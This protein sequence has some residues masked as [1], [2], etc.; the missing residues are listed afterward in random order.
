MFVITS[1]FMPP[2]PTGVAERHVSSVSIAI[3]RRL[4]SSTNARALGLFL[5]AMLAKVAPVARNV[6][7][8]R[9]GASVTSLP[10]LITARWA[11]PFLKKPFCV[12][13][14]VHR[15]FL[16]PSPLGSTATSM[17]TTAKGNF[18]ISFSGIEVSPLEYVP[19]SRSPVRSRERSERVGGGGWLSLGLPEAEKS[20][21]GV[22]LIAGGTKSAVVRSA[23]GP[24]NVKRRT[25]M[26]GLFWT[27]LNATTSRFSILNRGAT[28]ASPLP[29]RTSWRL[30]PCW[31]SHTLT[32]SP[33]AIWKR[34]V[35]L[36]ASISSYVTASA[37]SPLTPSTIGS[38]VNLILP[39]E[40]RTL[41]PGRMSV[42]STTAP[43][44][45]ASW[46]RCTVTRPRTSSVRPRISPVFG[47]RSS[48]PSRYAVN[49]TPA[50]SPSRCPSE[51]VSVVPWTSSTSPF[52]LG[53]SARTW[54]TR[55]PSVGGAVWADAP[56]A[57]RRS[58]ARTAE[59]CAGR[60]PFTI[61]GASFSHPD[62]KMKRGM[63]D[64]AHAPLCCAR[65]R[66]DL[67]AEPQAGRRQV[68]VV[69]LP[70]REHTVE[71]LAGI[72]CLP[73]REIRTR[74]IERHVRGEFPGEA[75]AALRTEV[76]G[77]TL[78]GASDVSTSSGRSL[79]RIGVDLLRRPR[80]VDR[81][82]PSEGRRER[83]RPPQTELATAVAVVTDVGAHTVGAGCA[84]ALVV[85][86]QAQD[87]GPGGVVARVEVERLEV[88][89]LPGEVVAGLVTRAVDPAGLEEQRPQ[90]VAPDD[91][92]EEGA[93]LCLDPLPVRAAGGG[94]TQN[95]ASTPLVI[96]GRIES[97]GAHAPA[98]IGADRVA[99]LMERRRAVRG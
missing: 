67:E 13:G 70:L 57:A 80:R 78:D 33:S 71:E 29:S 81:H 91:V 22:A 87:R 28:G 51:S 73:C 97:P 68:A 41:S 26:Y 88:V 82:P 19:A 65:W 27:R 96:E 1:S 46:T 7:G 6:L 83:V 23:L 76:A 34:P 94:E 10:S 38:S 3:R 92:E 61:A 64:T 30:I 75:Y 44:A 14:W 89:N 59:T 37:R 20:P 99:V 5:P 15:V 85:D 25:S 95:V 52:T 60:R 9:T 21:F 66:A 32:A 54:L 16:I 58:R 56:A 31:A 12:K 49:S 11:S 48:R 79:A 50:T 36:S 98:R 8:T 93:H 40:T 77:V 72:Q 47:W 90:L 4:Y 35:R 69:R 45:Y 42:P 84:A 55:T 53:K 39:A 86:T 63:G 74:P 43:V 17:A 2:P 62:S 24:G 18:A